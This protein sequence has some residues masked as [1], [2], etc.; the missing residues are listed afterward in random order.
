MN[1]LIGGSQ[2]SCCTLEWLPWCLQLS[3]SNQL[4]SQQVNLLESQLCL[5]QANLSALLEVLSVAPALP[6][7][8]ICPRGSNEISQCDHVPSEDGIG[9]EPQLGPPSEAGEI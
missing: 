3:G 8:T 6:P 1:N 2:V 4:C 9:K 5:Q 7:L